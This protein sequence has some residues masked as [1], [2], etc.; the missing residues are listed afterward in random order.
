VE[1]EEGGEA[2][3]AEE[4]EDRRRE[5]KEEWRVARMMTS[6]PRRGLEEGRAE[7]WG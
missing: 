6:L 7:E 1:E 3:E 4:G 5:R 2:G